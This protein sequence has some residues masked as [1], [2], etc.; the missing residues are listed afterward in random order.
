MALSHKAGDTE[1]VRRAADRFGELLTSLVGDYR[2]NGKGPLELL[3][4]PEKLAERALLAQA[5]VSS[6]WDELIGPF[7]RS[8]GVQARLRISRQAVAAKAARRRLLRVFTSDD[9]ALFP[10]WQ[11]AG[12]SVLPGLAEVLALFPEDLVDG[13][14]LAGWLRTKD[15]E[16]GAVPLDAL[17]EG[18]GDRVLAV[19]HSASAALAA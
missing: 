1:F 15:A 13:W 4:Q 5:P 17:V 3:G 18:E 12:R 2:Q 19:A 8:E 11:F 16:L 7:F 9:V 10:V 14:V 6:P